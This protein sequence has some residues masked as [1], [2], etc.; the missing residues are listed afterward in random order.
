VVLDIKDKEVKKK[1][2]DLTNKDIE[3]KNKS[4]THESALNEYEVVLA[5][6]E[7]EIQCWKGV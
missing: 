2:G 1:R 7:F 3:L 4:A 5:G 6:K